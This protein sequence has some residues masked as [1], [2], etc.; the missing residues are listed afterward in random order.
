MVYIRQKFY[1]STYY[2]AP[3]PLLH[4]LQSST[5]ECMC[6]PTAS[7]VGCIQ[8]VNSDS[9]QA[10]WGGDGGGTGS[11]MQFQKFIMGVARFIDE[12]LL[13]QSHSQTLNTSTRWCLAILY[14]IDGEILISHLQTEILNTPPPLPTF[15]IPNPPLA[16]VVTFFHLGSCYMVFNTRDALSLQHC[17]LGHCGA[18]CIWYFL[19]K[20][21]SLQLTLGFLHVLGQSPYYRFQCQL[22]LLPQAIWLSLKSISMTSFLEQ[23]LCFQKTQMY[24]P[25]K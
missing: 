1:Y 8:T 18:S 19:R 11:T 16:M 4:Q 9:L 6:R 21:N 25:N 15:G 12:P 24:H 3:P 5:A 17:Q 2:N 10:A 22:Y 20:N 23:F 14:Y 13:L 7:P